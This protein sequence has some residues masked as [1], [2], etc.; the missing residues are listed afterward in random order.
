MAV[1]TKQPPPAEPES[2]LV[3]A[4]EFLQ[5]GSKMACAELIAGRVIELSPAG[6]EHS[7]LGGRVFARLLAHADDTDAG[8]CTTADGGYVLSR[9]PDVVRAPDAAFVA[10]DRLP[11]G[12]APRMF[13]EGAPDIAVEVMSPSEAAGE[14]EAKT[15]Q[16]LRAGTRLVWIIYPDEKL[17]RVWRADGTTTLIEE[18]GSLVGEDVLPGFELPLGDVLR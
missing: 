2:R 18:D 3:T 8:M 4:E 16:Y 9:D 1:T 5:L 7:S 11:D 14:I 6:A 12:R 10:R 13:F 15:Q 17:A